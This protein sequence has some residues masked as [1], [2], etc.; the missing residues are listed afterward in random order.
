M[1]KFIKQTQFTA[2]DFER[3]RKRLHENLNALKTLLAQ[4]GFGQGAPSFGAE[5]E[6]YI[7]NQQGAAKPDNIALQALLNDKQLT[8]ELNRFN[9][10][11]N[12]IPV[13]QDKAPFTKIKKQMQN[14]LTSL[15]DA[16]KNRQA[17]ILPIGILPT[18]QAK[19]LGLKA[20]TDLPRYNILAKTLRRQRD[21]DFHIHICGE[22]VLDIHWPDISPEGAA[23]SFQFH[24]R[25]NP[26]D[27]AD[28]YNAAQLTTPLVLALSANSPFFLG[29][30][31][32]Q[33]TRIVLFKQATD[34]RT[35]FALD[36]HFPARVSYG[37]GWNRKDVYELFAEGVYLFDPVMPVCSEDNP[38]EQLSAG[39][40]P[41]LSELRLHMGSIWNWNRAIYDPLDNGH[42]R[43]ELRSLPAGPSPIN[44]LA[45]AALMSGLMRGLQSHLTDILPNLPFCYT[46]K[47]FYRAAKYGLKARLFWPNL[48]TGKLQE[49]SVINILKD[50]LP[51]AEDGLCQLGI[52]ETEIRQQMAIIHAGL[53]SRMNGAQWQINIFDKLMQSEERQTALAQLVELYYRQYQTGKAVHEWSEEI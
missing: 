32:W 15:A 27:F 6:L 35:K 26:D 11:Y 12:F 53:E 13:V 38:F 43:I 46:E 8:F 28:I 14:V 31:L 34:C 36:N 23:T 37:L 3:Y 52:E 40:A 16:A 20:L 10:E 21:S 44:M 17:R 22:D 51:F 29:R 24:Y 50:L 49:R 25:V 39:H 1:G 47:N 9:L 33:E 30:K 5:L 41:S 7:I 4:P 45:S 48:K 42:L 18:L 2:R 19:D